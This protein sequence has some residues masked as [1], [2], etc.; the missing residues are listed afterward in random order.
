MINR[1]VYRCGCASHV[2][3]LP[4][5]WSGI[6]AVLVVLVVRTGSTSKD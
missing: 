2:P 4:M 6:V 1:F 5:V 3:G